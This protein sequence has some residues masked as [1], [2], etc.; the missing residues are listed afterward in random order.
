MCLKCHLGLSDSIVCSE[1]REE[2]DN[3]TINFN[4]Y[5]STSICHII[6][7][8][9]GYNGLGVRNKAIKVLENYYK[10]V[11]LNPKYIIN[12]KLSR[13]E[14]KPKPQKV[15]EKKMEKEKK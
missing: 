15:V 3:G 7:A 4:I 8:C 6:I 5:N 13:S 12:D 11:I 14:T 9:S 1:M 2:L 10:W